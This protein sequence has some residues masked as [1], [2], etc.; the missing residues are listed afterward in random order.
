MTRL[1]TRAIIACVVMLTVSISIT[2]TLGARLPAPQVIY[3]AQEMR[4]YDVRAGHSIALADVRSA[5]PVSLAWSPD[6]RYIAYYTLSGV[7]YH[8]TVLDAR[9][10]RHQSLTAALASGAAASWSPD[11]ARVLV[12]KPNESQQVEACALHLVDFS[13]ACAALAVNV[14][15]ATWSPREALWAMVYQGANGQCVGL[16]NVDTQH[17]QD[18]EC[19]AT[20]TRPS[21]SPDGAQVV[22]M[23]LKGSDTAEVVVRHI[24]EGSETRYRPNVMSYLAEWQSD[25][26][27]LIQGGHK[28]YLLNPQNGSIT[29]ANQQPSTRHASALDPTER[30]EA[31]VMLLTQGD[32]LE[33]LVR[34]SPGYNSAPIER[35]RRVDRVSS[36]AFAWRP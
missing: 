9:T 19:G 28:D 7:A 8:L 16:F 1:L 22:Y 11:S 12:L 24:G 23:R 17:L 20:Y 29:P 31:S 3:T 30:Y 6:G 21:W 10:L 13:L 18:Y 14:S 35:W 4:L 36:Y 15:M 2:T 32:A 34:R 33:L 27:I 25:T 26:R 5:T